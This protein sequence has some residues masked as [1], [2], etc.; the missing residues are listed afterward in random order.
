MYKTIILGMKVHSLIDEMVMR[1]PFFVLPAIAG[2]FDGDVLAV[3]AWEKPS[4]RL[5][6]FEALG[7]QVSVID[8]KTIKYNSDI[9]P[10]NN[11]AVLLYKGFSCDSILKETIY[12]G[13]KGKS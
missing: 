10:N 11:T 7:P 5:R 13:K 3:I 12:G 9:G 2:D 6:I 8:T 1:I 4:E